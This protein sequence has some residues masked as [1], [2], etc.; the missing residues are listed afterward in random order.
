MFELEACKKLMDNIAEWVFVLLF[1][2]V[3][4]GYSVVLWMGAA[5]DWAWLTDTPTMGIHS[6]MRKFLS[7]DEMRT[8]CRYEA[9]V[10]ATFSTYV[11]VGSFVRDA[12]I[13][14]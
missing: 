12:G 3:A 11:S 4:M 5:R 7:R 10:L 9:V 6:F 1:Y 8:F 13:F 2:V 14:R